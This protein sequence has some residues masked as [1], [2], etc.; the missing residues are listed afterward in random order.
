MLEPRKRM[1]IDGKI[2]WCVFDAETLKYSTLL[3]FGKYKTKRD[4]Q[5][6]IDK[7]LN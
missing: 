1:A 7:C 4:C 3:C 5:Y 2:W 6:D